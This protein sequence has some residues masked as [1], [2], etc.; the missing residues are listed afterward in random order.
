MEAGWW[1]K[2]LQVFKAHSLRGAM[3]TDPLQLG[4]Q[5]DVFRSTTKTLDTKNFRPQQFRDWKRML[6]G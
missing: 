6:S 3:A 4:V 2:R 1:W 5:A